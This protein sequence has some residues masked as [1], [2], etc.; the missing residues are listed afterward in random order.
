MFGS[1]ISCANDDGV[2]PPPVVIT[3]MAEK[4]YINTCCVPPKH[5]RTTEKF[6]CMITILFL[7]KKTGMH[8]KH[9]SHVDTKHVMGIVHL[10][11]Y[12]QLGHFP[13]IGHKCNTSRSIFQI[14]GNTVVVL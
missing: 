3:H 2:P 12:W 13:Q 4:V 10:D 6:G 14:S 5:G 11:K 8:D 9:L 7:K 1:I